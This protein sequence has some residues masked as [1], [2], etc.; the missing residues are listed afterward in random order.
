MAY[1]EMFPEIF[2]DM[3]GNG[4][5]TL[6]KDIMSRVKIVSGVKNNILNFDYYDGGWF[7]GGFLL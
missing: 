3:K 4:E 6:V 5:L 1:F 2:Y 7:W